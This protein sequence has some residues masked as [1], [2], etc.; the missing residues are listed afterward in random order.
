MVEVKRAARPRVSATTLTLLRRTSTRKPPS[1]SEPLTDSEHSLDRVIDTLAARYPDVD[2]QTVA[3]C[4]YATYARL[5][6]KGP[7]PPT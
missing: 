2:K 6:E 5:R 1:E 4:V 3:D 7:S